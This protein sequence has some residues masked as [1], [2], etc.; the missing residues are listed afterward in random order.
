[1]Q[2]KSVGATGGLVFMREKEL[3]LGFSVL[4]THE[5]ILSFAQV[6]KSTY[7]CSLGYCRVWSHSAKATKDFCFFVNFF[8]HNERSA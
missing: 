2:K 4:F 3:F 5:N 6:L 8:I 7:V 1:M